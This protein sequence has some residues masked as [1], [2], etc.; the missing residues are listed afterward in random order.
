MEAAIAALVP[1]T[2]HPEVRGFIRQVIIEERR[3][4][5]GYFPNGIELSPLFADL[6][7]A[8]MLGAAR[9]MASNIRWARQPT[10][11]SP[12]W[13]CGLYLGLYISSIDA[14]YVDVDLI[15]PPRSQYS[16]A[17]RILHFE[18]DDVHHT[19]TSEVFP[20]KTFVAR[21]GRHGIKMCKLHQAQSAIITN[22]NFVSDGGIARYVSHEDVCSEFVR[23]TYPTPHGD[24]VISESVATLGGAAADIRLES[25]VVIVTAGDHS[26]RLGNRRAEPI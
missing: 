23:V 3:V 24:L 22:I 2:A 6:D 5:A 11:P 7:P 17:S 20:G 18:A 14:I 26:F 16:P 15:K 10:R 13:F 9:I 1:F 12:I 8:T 4:S 25:D 19:W 21:S